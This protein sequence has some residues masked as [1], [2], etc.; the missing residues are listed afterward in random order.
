MDK[1]GGLDLAKQLSERLWPGEWRSHDL[2]GNELCAISGSYPLA[3]FGPK[4]TDRPEAFLAL[5][6]AVAT[7]LPVT[8]ALYEFINSINSDAWP[9]EA[10]PT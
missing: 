6:C 2:L 8:P 5:N 10:P 7:G 4:I 3:I 1:S 9:R